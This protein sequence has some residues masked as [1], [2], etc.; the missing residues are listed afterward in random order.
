MKIQQKGVRFIRFNKVFPL[1][2]PTEGRVQKLMND[3]AE[4]SDKAFGEGPRTV[5]IINHLK[6]KMSTIFIINF[7]E[8]NR[9]HVW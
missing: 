5:P 4:W 6:K 9:P 2:P 8:P 3:V 1:M 7:T